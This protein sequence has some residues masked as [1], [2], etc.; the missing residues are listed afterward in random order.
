VPRLDQRQPHQFHPTRRVADLAE[1]RKA[2]R[3][4]LRFPDQELTVGCGQ[5]AG[6]HRLVLVGNEGRIVRSLGKRP[7]QREIRRRR[8]TQHQTPTVAAK[9]VR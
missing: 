5:I 6:K 7:N 3:F 1:N 8:R 9:A 2:G 4:A